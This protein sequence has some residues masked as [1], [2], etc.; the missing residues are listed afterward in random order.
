MKNQLNQKNILILILIKKYPFSW[1]CTCHKNLLTMLNS[2]NSLLIVKTSQLD[3][4]KFYCRLYHSAIPRR[5][6]HINFPW[7]QKRYLKFYTMNAK[8]TFSTPIYLPMYHS[9]CFWK[10]I[11]LQI[12]KVFGI[13]SYSLT[14]RSLLFLEHRTAHC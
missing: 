5:L 13:L 6:Q 12:Q 9:Q 1:R 3:D 7:S 2:L 11:C 4:D 14:C 10:S 8:L